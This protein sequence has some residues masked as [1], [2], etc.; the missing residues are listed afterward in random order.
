MEKKNDLLE[1]STEF[2]LQ[3]IVYCELLEQHHKYVIAR[4]LLRSGT[5]V[6]ANAR[7]AQNSESRS[8]FIHKLKISAKEANEAA[9]WLE[10]CEKSKSYP[11]P[12]SL[13]A[14][15]LRIE[16]ILSSIIATMKKQV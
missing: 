3:L 8:D 13:S 2:S 4:Q 5:S 14:R 15:L 6:G 9:Y 12:G 1:L 11:D 16:K 7:E 10:L